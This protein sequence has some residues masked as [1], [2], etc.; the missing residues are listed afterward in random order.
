MDGNS[1]EF[2]NIADVRKKMKEHV[3][4]HEKKDLTV[5]NILNKEFQLVNCES[6]LFPC[7][8]NEDATITITKDKML[9]KFN[10]GKNWNLSYSVD[11]D[12]IIV[13][14]NE[15]DGQSYLRIL[16]I[17]SNSVGICDE[18]SKKEV[19]AHA[20][21]TEYYVI[22][23]YADKFMTEM[24]KHAKFTG[25]TP[26][27][28]LSK[29]SNIALHQMYLNGDNNKVMNDKLI[30][31][32]SDGKYTGAEATAE[33]NTDGKLIVTDDKGEK[34]D[35]VVAKK[36]NLKGITINAKD[37]SDEK[38]FSVHN[39]IGTLPSID[40]KF[41]SDMYMYCNILN[42]RCWFDDTAINEVVTALKTK[43]YSNNTDNNN[44]TGNNT[45]NNNTTGN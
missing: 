10:N 26:L 22:P 21:A 14:D 28:K 27:T 35:P 18:D 13:R 20:K 31:I 45:D 25:G 40:I 34:E 12:N 8:K 41:N 16:S 37:L 5:K 36:Y 42:E 38:M 19:Q 11:D 30:T 2:L 33:F 7:E 39:Y 43:D 44:T 1:Y 32:A 9:F 29:I 3:K 17:S 24:S 6:S 23:S 15:G 4:G